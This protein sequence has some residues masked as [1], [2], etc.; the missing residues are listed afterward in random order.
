MTP[1][2]IISTA[3][4]ARCERERG[5]RTKK[6]WMLRE[7]VELE[8]ESETFKNWYYGDNAPPTPAI[9]KLV[10]RYGSGFRDEIFPCSNDEQLTPERA[11]ETL[12]RFI[13]EQRTGEL[14]SVE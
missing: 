10:A 3:L 12:E 6:S 8:E 13:A 5:D 9:Y 4:Q 14:R 7:A 1:A 11:L 2:D